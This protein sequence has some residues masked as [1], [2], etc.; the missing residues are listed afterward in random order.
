MYKAILFD[1]DGT[2]ID[3]SE[4]ILAA[5]KET[6]DVLHIDPLSDDEIKSCIGPPI[7]ETL[8]KLVGFSDSEKKEFY[9]VFRSLYK[10]KYLY[11]CEIYPGIIS[12]LDELREKGSFVGIATN[13]RK[14]STEDLLDH[15][16]IVDR[17]DIVVAQDGVFIREKASMVAEAMD[18]LNVVKEDTVLIGDSISDLNAAKKAEIGFIGVRYGFGF[19]EDLDESYEFVGTVEELR[20]LL[21]G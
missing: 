12:L 6:F 14:D 7:G 17:F 2:L 5:V 16:A 4:G 1:L 3:S 19:K 11:R 20:S 15:L 9:G 10:E 13:K 18:L 8:Q 21:I